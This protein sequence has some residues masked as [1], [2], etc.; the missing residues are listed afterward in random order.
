MDLETM[1]QM[2]GSVSPMMRA[3]ACE[4]LSLYNHNTPE[5]IS[6][7]ENATHDRDRKVSDA[8]SKTLDKLQGIIPEELRILLSTTAIIEGHRI[9]KYLGIISSEVVLGTGFL[10]ELD[11]GL[12]DLLGAR[13][14]KFQNKI[15]EAKDLTI[16]ELCNK[17]VKLNA[18]AV[19]GIDLDYSVLSKNMLMVVASGTAVQIGEEMA[20]QNPENQNLNK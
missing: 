8:A 12:A 3:Q 2:L 10:S 7:L 17:A 20:S 14:D 9:I 11:A 1:L 5:I 6:A 18:N 15:K 16:K 19:I 13:S 4:A